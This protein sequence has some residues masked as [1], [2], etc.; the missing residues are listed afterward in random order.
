V[1]RKERFFVG[2]LVSHRRYGYR[3]VI[4]GRDPRCR[5]D[6]SWYFSNRTQP[7]RNQPWYHVL[8][9]GGMHT[10]YVAEENL[11][12]YTGG[13]QVVHPLTRDLF[14]S[15]SAGHYQPHEGVEF[16]APW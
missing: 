13:E 8:V 1:Q 5:A 14:A 10:T 12:P 7:E 15:F 4:A 6:E 2:Q 9:H 16:P 3:G 11:E